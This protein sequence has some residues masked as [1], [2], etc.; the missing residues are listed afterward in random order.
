MC[1][2]DLHDLVTVSDDAV[3]GIRLP[4]DGRWRDW[5]TGIRDAI[6]D[7]V[8]CFVVGCFVVGFAGPWRVMLILCCVGVLFGV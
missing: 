4:L 3:R 2:N 6:R 1:V 7:A 8:S 5:M